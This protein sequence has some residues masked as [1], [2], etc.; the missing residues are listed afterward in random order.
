MG[1]EVSK[2]YRLARF[3][4]FY[5]N[6]TTLVVS[7]TG[8]I[9]LWMKTDFTDFCACPMLTVDCGIVPVVMST[10]P[11]RCRGELACCIW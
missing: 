1:S 5:R 8:E 4:F 9:L 2:S 6:F 11:P 3:D 10:P 7:V